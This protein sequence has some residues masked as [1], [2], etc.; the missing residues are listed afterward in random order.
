LTHI[1]GQ[2]GNFTVTVKKKPRYIDMDK[3]IACGIC[4]EKCPKKVDDDYNAG[5]NARKAAYIKYAQT[6]PQKYLL[7]EKNCIYL[8][9]GKCKAC[10]KFCPTGAI[11]FDDKEKVVTL[12]VG[13]LILSP[14]FTPFDPAP[15]EFFG[16]NQFPD[17]VTSL[18][19][20]RLLSAGG[21]CM[22]H[23]IRPSDNKEPKKIAWI[24]C[25]G[26]RNT[27]KCENEF[28]S[29]V[30]CMYSMKQARI[31]Q[32]HMLKE[33]L[34]LTIF[35]IDIRSHG[36]DFE[37]YYN[38]TKDRGVRF[39]R[40]RP[41]TINPGKNN[42][43]V[44]MDYLSEDGQ[45]L[46]EDFDMAVLAI[47]LSAPQDAQTLAALTGIEL[48][49]FKFA[50]SSCFEPVIT[51]KPG[52]FAAGAFRSAKAIP[53]SVTEASAAAAHASLLLSEARDTL[54]K[55]KTYPAEHDVKGEVPRVGVFVCSCGVNIA[56][57]V[58]VKSV[59]E[60]A[61]TLPHVVLVENNMF[62]C[63]TDTQ[64]IMA[65]KIREHNLNRLVVAAC[66]PRTHE[67]LFQD[68]LKEAGLNAYLFEMANIRNQNA[69]VH[70]NSPV[71]ATAK[72]KDQVRMAVAKSV[73]N[74][75]LDRP[76]VNVVQKAMV[77]GGGISG[78]TAALQFA[79]QGFQTTLLEKSDKLGGNAWSLNHTYKGED[80]QEKLK[81]IITKVEGNPNISVLK[82]AEMRSVSGSVG[83]F[84]SE[85][86]SNGTVHA[87]AYGVAVLATGA[88]EY[89]P[90]EYFFGQD[91]RVMTQLMFDKEIKH[92]FDTLQKAQ[93][94][95]FIQ[96]VGSREEQRPYCSRNCC[97]HTVNAAIAL[98]KINPEM[99]VYVLNR[100]L[101]TYG[102]RE[103]LYKKARELGVI[104]IRYYKDDKP[105]VYTQD[106]DLFVELFDP[107]SRRQLKIYA[108]YLVLAAA[109]IPYDNKDLID[110][111]KCS[112]NE[113]GFLNEA[114]PKLRPVDMSVEGLF[115][116]GL[117]NYPKP[118][119]ESIAQAEAAVSR[120]SVILVR[121]N[122]ELDAIKSFT[123]EK[124]DGC[125]I[126]LDVCPY[127]AITLEEYPQNGRTAKRI[128]SDEALCKGCGLCQ[129]TCPKEGVYIHGFTLDQL[130]AQVD[131]AL[132]L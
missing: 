38:D 27:N 120:A 34:D 45:K 32:E 65:S 28:C 12:N 100:E 84:F 80:I 61:G 71:E 3:C 35:Y 117:C 66:S 37:K 48:D 62:A 92:N 14:G 77:I 68:T 53:R 57:V 54:A 116:A 67:P 23:L 25:V 129:A 44:S 72:A 1:A 113:D 111:Y 93:S 110:L 118:I 75:P 2:A 59:A 30:C 60:Y 85:V 63:S 17:V 86:T 69:W 52:I 119:E 106:K 83:N 47:G 49:S 76:K 4:A 87:I 125:A 74:Y 21:P 19:Y 26:S 95:V 55:V 101:R 58:D 5:L 56:G 128:K 18:E 121:E 20:E 131:A 39:V 64:N 11:N 79:D 114:H 130:K 107:I 102:M 108:D 41:H 126:C 109:I 29:S 96:C 91:N 104:F 89:Q 15:F 46:T 51:N 103:L 6:V 115:V 9:N 132:N 36:K 13:A 73:M 97:T 98:K 122:K 112:V 124:C 99:N 24:Q 78:M 50:K 10:E 127:K 105:K 82:N 33:K 31:T 43:G 22:G 81:G 7:D 40:A 88:T 16:Y 90:T 123:T 42:M 70:Q 94:V 8:K